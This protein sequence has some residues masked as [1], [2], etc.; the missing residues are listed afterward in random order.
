MQ[1]SIA[2]SGGLC[3]HDVIASAIV[4][5]PEI[6][7]YDEPTT[8]LEPIAA[9]SIDR[10]IVRISERLCATSIAVTHDMRS[11]GRIGKKIVMLH[12]G[13]IHATGIPDE[14]FKSTDPV[15]SRFV[16]GLSDPKEHAF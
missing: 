3:N 16:N 12:E 6:L 4:Y 11:A 14:I 15:V 13:R 7:L 8:D 5:Q 2:L 9:D 10:L 1:W